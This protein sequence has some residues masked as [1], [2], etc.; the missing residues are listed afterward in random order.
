[1]AAVS[2]PVFARVYERI[3]ELRRFRFPTTS[4]SPSAPCAVGRAVRTDERQGG[5]P[6]TGSAGWPAAPT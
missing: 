1:M 2:H 6:L 5:A 3:E 4:S